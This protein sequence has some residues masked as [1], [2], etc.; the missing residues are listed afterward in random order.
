MLIT[1]DPDKRAATLKHRNLDFE[2]APKLFAGKH[3]HMEDDREDYGET[4]WITVGRLNRAMVVVV[5]TQRDEARRI[6]SMRK[7]NAREQERYRAHLD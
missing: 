2:D 1:Y 5:W 3:F 7:C 6:I 4:R